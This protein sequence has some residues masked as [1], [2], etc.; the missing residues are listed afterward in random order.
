MARKNGTFP[1]ELVDKLT[2]SFGEPV[3]KFNSFIN[4]IAENALERENLR[5][6]IATHLHYGG[7]TVKGLIVDDEHLNDKPCKVSLKDN[8]FWCSECTPKFCMHI[9]YALLHPKIG[10]LQD[11]DGLKKKK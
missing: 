1:A 2:E 9:T 10:Q 5:N 8:R 4:L 3:E 7:I 11:Q 6:S